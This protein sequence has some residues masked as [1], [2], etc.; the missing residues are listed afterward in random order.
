MIKNLGDIEYRL[1]E[2]MDRL[3]KKVKQLDII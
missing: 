3:Q 1:K 2:P